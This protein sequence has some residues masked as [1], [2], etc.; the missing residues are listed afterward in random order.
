M[1]DIIYRAAL[2]LC[3]STAFQSIIKSSQESPTPPPPPRTARSHYN[4]TNKDTA[5]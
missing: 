4:I 2:A 5:E 1:A 3:I